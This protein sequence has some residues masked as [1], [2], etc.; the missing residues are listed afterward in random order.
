[1]RCPASITR[2]QLN[3]CMIR[4][5]RRLNLTTVSCTAAIAIAMPTAIYTLLV[6]IRTTT[7][8]SESLQRLSATLVRIEFPAPSDPYTGIPGQFVRRAEFWNFVR[9]VTMGG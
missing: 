9:P 1:M 5:V 8:T 7:K 6:R 4:I 3:H 2:P